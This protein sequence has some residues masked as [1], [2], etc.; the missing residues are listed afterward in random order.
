MEQSS[1]RSTFDKASLINQLA[2][3]FSISERRNIKFIYPSIE[4]MLTDLDL[5]MYLTLISFDKAKLA[6]TKIPVPFK[7]ETRGEIIFGFIAFT[8]Y[9]I[10]LSKYFTKYIENCE[11]K[12]DG[13]YVNGV[14][15]SAEEYEYIAKVTLIS[16]GIEKVDEEEFSQNKP[17]NV[18][19]LNPEIQ[20]ILQKQKEAQERL[21]K[22][23]QKKAKQS[24]FT[25]DKVMLAVTY[26]FGIPMKD[27]IKLN[28]YAIFWYFGFVGKVDAH[29]LN[30]LIISS[31]F[32]KKKD[33]SYWLNK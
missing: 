6:E 32:S 28:Y 14:R 4:E 21:N 11:E 8:D 33:Y 17:E 3:D 29:K 12:E 18:Q 15:I 24:G 2:V 19:K 31:G 27:L 1:I 10:V 7:A 25:I 9:K 20:A 23:K 16:C 5:Q 13:L 30:Q 26:E 22:I